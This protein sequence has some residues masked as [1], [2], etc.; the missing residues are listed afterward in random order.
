[1]SHEGHPKPAG[2]T[3][4]SR[5]RRD[6]RPSIARWA[7]RVAFLVLVLLVAWNI[8]GEH[9][10][11]RPSVKVRSCGGNFNMLRDFSAAFEKK[12]G[13][14]VQYVGAPVQFLLE[15]ALADDRNLP[16]VLV[17]RSGPGWQVLDERGKLKASREFFAMDPIV[18]A[19]PKGNPAGVKSIEDLG[20]EGVRVT[21]APWAMRPKGMVF[22]HLMF[23]VSRQFHPGLVDRWERNMGVRE[24][25]G[26]LIGRAIV[27]GRADAALVP[28][29][30]TTQAPLADRCDVIEIPVEL[31]DT[32]TMGRASI[33]QSVARTA[34]NPGN[35]LADLYVEELLGEPGHT[36]LV[37]Q[38]YIPRSSP[39]FARFAP[40]LA[41]FRPE[42]MAP[43][44]MKLAALLRQDGVGR[45]VVRRY[46]KVINTFGPGR[47]DAEAWYRIGEFLAEQGN[48]R[49]ARLAWTHLI[50]SYP[51]GGHKEW[52]HT[53]HAV[54]DQLGDPEAPWLARARSELQ[55]LPKPRRLKQLP[56]IS[57]KPIQVRQGDPPKGATRDLALAID[58]YRVG[59]HDFALRDAFKVL[60][61]HY[62]SPQMSQ[63]RAVAGA[64]LYAKGDRERAR[65]QWQQVL[66]D[67]PDSTWAEP[68]QRAIDAMVALSAAPDQT[69][70]AAKDDLFAP[71]CD[72]SRFLSAGPPYPSHADRGMKYAGELHRAG[73]PVF[74][75]KECLKVLVG[76]YGQH[77][78]TARA[79]YCAGLCLE[80]MG[81]NAAAV[82]QW[83]TCEKAEPE[84]KWSGM[85]REA[86]QRVGPAPV[87]PHAELRAK[88]EIPASFAPP[89]LAKP[90]GK[91]AGRGEAK[92]SKEKTPAAVKRFRLGEELLAA[93][94]TEDDQALQEFLKVLTVVPVPP[95]ARWTQS[96]A[97]VRAAQT[98]LLS[99]KVDA[100]R[101]HLEA[102]TRS[103]GPRV[104]V[105]Q[106]KRLL[107]EAGE[108][109]EG[110]P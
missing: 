38:G 109:E 26:R 41:P 5:C 50:D 19:V 47:W 20:R 33:P 10:Y 37:E 70:L 17:G 2:G 22:S 40:F 98:L 55:S 105:E 51:T 58:L 23:Q 29:S 88:Y 59:V 32:L 97:H 21:S 25:C 108:S 84:S 12:H 61:L 53:F 107:A 87:F 27:D 72:L 86:I 34:A 100:A 79:R 7:D 104:Y 91:L 73:L 80:E 66:R 18:V 89:G 24:D 62:P 35:H 76:L 45:E 60:S 16:D 30:L 71:F 85:A 95:E 90:E 31:L 13:C 103:D 28:L 67:Y 52:I 102:A 64:A 57:F 93:G 15:L 77:R 83:N 4:D 44:Q 1:M 43:R 69:S 74:A 46:L 96:A 75:L 99:G 110:Q 14:C 54:R 48:P 3:S 68:C 78:H 6:W 92:S 8:F 9:A 42:P 82:V 36:I 81:L 101:R 65:R 56:P 11:W 39:H 63:A 49:G 106:A 94:I